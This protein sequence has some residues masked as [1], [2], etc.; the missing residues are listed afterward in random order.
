MYFLTYFHLKQEAVVLPPYI[1]FAVR[2]NP[3]F[4]E[5]VKVDANDL[6]VEAITVTEY[7]KLKEVTVDEN[8]YDATNMAV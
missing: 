5:Y 8:W 7:L 4:W 3:G 1:A 6:A 2:P